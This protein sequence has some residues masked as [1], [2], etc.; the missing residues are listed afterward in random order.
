MCPQHGFTQ[1]ERQRREA[2]GGKN[3]LEE[4]QIFY[5]EKVKSTFQSWN[6]ALL[7]IFR[8]RES[9][10]LRGSPT[11]TTTA[12]W[13]R[14]NVET[15]VITWIFIRCTMQICRILLVLYWLVDIEEW[16]MVRIMWDQPEPPGKG[17]G[18]GNDR[19]EDEFSLASAV[20][21]RE[22]AYQG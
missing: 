5:A 22:V 11:W 19:E 12:C 2:S 18:L 10:E 13:M 9:W 7:S 6:N 1:G 8:E 20:S 17:S 3:V 15:K 16:I 4:K 14:Q 21:I